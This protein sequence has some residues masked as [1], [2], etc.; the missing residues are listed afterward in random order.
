MHRFL[1]AVVFLFCASSLAAAQT[2]SPVTTQTAPPAAYSESK[3]YQPREFAAPKNSKPKKEKKSKKNEQA[4]NKT[5]IADNP[6]GDVPPKIVDETITIPVS[7]FDAGGRFVS[8]LRQADFK[9][10]ADGEEQEITSVTRRDEP[11]NLIL[12]VDTSPSTEYNI[13]EIQNYAQ[14]II[15]QLKPGDKVMGIAFNQE[16]KALT[17]LTADRQVTAKALRKLK[18]GNG[19]ALY[20]A[21]K[22]TFGKYVSQISGLKTVVLLTDGVD[23]TSLR[24]GYADSLTAAEQSDA[25]VFPIYFDT[26]VINK[27]A[28]KNSG[29][30]PPNINIAGNAAVLT[31]AE[32]E[33]GRFY[34]NDIARLSGGRPQQVKDISDVRPENIGNIGA[35]LR[36]QYQISFRPKNFTIGQR[37]QITVRVN[38]PNLFVQARGSLI[39]GA[40]NKV[41][42]A[43]QK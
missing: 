12:L 21:V 37:K 43:K 42:P 34:L 29:F 40:E 5:P 4:E 22:N 41:E 16:L 17:E 27:K 31:A 2:E 38:R 9:I 18:F 36:A 20:E 15:G 14:A 28:T 19:T 3:P 11:V 33:L 23:T 26:S 32:Y 35:E 7:V 39:A 1:I 6:T 25:A 24:A 8:N 13:E 30:F 10:F